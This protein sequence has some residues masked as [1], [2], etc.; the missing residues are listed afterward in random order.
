LVPDIDS[1]NFSSPLE[2]E[3]FLPYGVLLF[4]F[5]GYSALPDM[6]DVLGANSRRAARKIIFLSLLI[7]AIFYLIFTLAVL[8]RAGTETS[9]DALSGLER[10]AGKGVVVVGSLIGL[11]AVFTSYIVFGADLKLLFRYDYNI[12]GSLAWLLAFLP[13]VLLF[14]FG[15][16][17]LV[18]ILNIVGS[19]GLGVFGAFIVW[20]SWKERVILSSFLGFMPRAFW[21]LSLGILVVLGA[22]QSLF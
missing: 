19:V 22:V 6:H 16:T 14:L 8:G 7:S 17:N 1:V 18:K 5:G 3:W 13:P 21:L 9:Q 2:P 10:M 15:F 11:L 20:I 4:A 12:S